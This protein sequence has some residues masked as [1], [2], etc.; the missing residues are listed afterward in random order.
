MCNLHIVNPYNKTGGGKVSQIGLQNVLKFTKLFNRIYTYNFTTKK[1]NIL[2]ICKLIFFLNK[3]KHMNHFLILQG[4]F[5]FEYLL[6]DFFLVNKKRLIII[7]RGAFV[8]NLSSFKF[9]KKPL[10]KLLL[11]KIFIKPRFKKSG[12]WIATSDLE[13]KRYLIMGA[14]Q[15]KCS[16]IPDSYN[17]NRF[18]AVNLKI[19]PSFLY[20]DYLLFVGRISK[21]KNIIFLIDLLNELNQTGFCK[22][23]IL[24]GPILD[25]EYFNE[26]RFVITKYGLNDS[27]IFKEAKNDSELKSFYLNAN[28][29]LLP[30]FIESFGLV[31]LEAMQFNK[32]IFV[33][34]NVPLNFISSNYGKELKLNVK[35]WK[36][37]IMNFQIYQNKF[38][39]ISNEVFDKFSIENIS[40]LWGDTIKKLQL[41]NL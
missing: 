2:V 34:N 23:L 35:L 41:G 24:V 15:N 36:D 33:S 25:K 9:V 27:I 18:N 20:T 29:V 37:E 12:C 19:D 11:W 4:V 39:N 13:M 31:V 16:I 26:V 17:L 28:C 3:R 7:P 38:P 6:V 14:N 22:K 10:L 40:S 1:Q 21:E 8:P 5:E 32:M 30:S